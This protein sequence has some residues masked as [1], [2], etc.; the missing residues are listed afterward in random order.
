MLYRREANW[1]ERWCSKKTKD[2]SLKKSS[3]IKDG[4][5]AMSFN[6]EQVFETPRL[7]YEEGR[8]AVT[9]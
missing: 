3:P 6:V 9:L 5:F 8:R 4:G 7:V 2:V 1:L